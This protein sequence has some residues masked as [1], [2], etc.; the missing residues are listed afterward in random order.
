[1]KMAYCMAAILV[2]AVLA[3]SCKNRFETYQPYSA[4]DERMAAAEQEH[5]YA[6]AYQNRYSAVGDDT[7]VDH[8]Q[9]GTP[10]SMAGKTKPN[11]ETDSGWGSFFDFGNHKPAVNIGA[12]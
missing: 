9:V 2:S 1:M 3:T 7:V 11:P 5:P 6:N 4:F 12:M 10:V 8:D